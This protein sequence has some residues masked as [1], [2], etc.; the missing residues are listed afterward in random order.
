MDGELL[1]RPAL[2]NEL[3]GDKTRFGYIGNEPFKATL[4][5]Q[6]K[7]LLLAQYVA[8]AVYN[9]RL[10]G[11]LKIPAP[12]NIPDLTFKE[13]KL[14]STAHLVGGDIV[15]PVAGVTLDYWKLQLVPTGDPNQAGVVSVRTGRL[16][17]TAAGISET[18]HFDEP[19]ELT[20]GEILADGNLGELFIDYN[21]YGQR[22]DG[23]PYTPQ[24]L[25]L[26]T[27]VIGRTDGYLATCGTVHF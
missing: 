16:V 24:S 17:F 26:S 19:F 21:N 12:C 11:K 14:T 13:M 10:D 8:S 7:Q 15:L 6:E 3:L 23:L 1:V 9:S 22:F 20:W 18:V 2:P 5:S 25:I 4:M 27:Y